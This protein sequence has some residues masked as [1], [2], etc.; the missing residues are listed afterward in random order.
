MKD[1]IYIFT[2]TCFLSTV[3]LKAT[4][5]MVASPGNNQDIQPNLQAASINASAGDILMLPAGQFVVNKCV[6]FTKALTV[7][8]MGIGQTV[9]YRSQTASDSLLTNSSQW[10]GIFKFK[11]YTNAPCGMV[12]TG[13]TFKSK[14]PSLV[15]GDGLSLAADFGII[16]DHCYNF[17]V[18]AC[19]FEN[20]GYAAVEV[21]HDDSIV[22]GLINKNEFLHNA[23]GAD[24]LGLGYG[25][26]VFGSNNKWIVNPRLGTSN[27]IFVEDNTFDFQRHA[28]AAGGCGL[29]VFRYNHVFNNIAGGGDHA[30][31]AHAARFSSG[32]NYFGTRAVEVYN[33]SLIN[34]T[35]VNGQLIVPGQSASL[36]SNN[37]ILVKAGDALIHD[38]YISGYRFGI[39][40]IDDNLTGTHPYPVLS[41]TGYL[42]GLKY[43]PNHTGWA[44]DYGDGDLYYWNTSFVPY[45][46]HD[47]SSEFYN[48]QPQYFEIYRD[49]HIV[50]KPNISNFQ[51][52][53]PLSISSAS[54]LGTGDSPSAPAFQ[55]RYL[56][57]PNPATDR[58]RLTSALELHVNID[59]QIIQSN[60]KLIHSYSLS[61]QTS[62]LDISMLPSGIYFIQIRDQEGAEI[63]KIL[64]A[65]KN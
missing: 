10:Q 19:H 15:V 38:N 45:P 12:V 43:G 58:I 35:F 50:P 28:I 9:L 55:N 11:M 21:F 48:Y 60:G 22:G 47:S 8:G 52:P 5:I 42:S 54:P 46:G 41:Q 37:G 20:F 13:I 17:V 2:L 7:K 14:K 25:V 65:R 26:A 30:V 6:L 29:Y 61:G 51:Y 18:T 24:A 33:D 27:F 44:G 49:Y 40:M 31:D 34:K 53:H 62:D 36:L 1:L 4:I 63:H 56:V 23:K 64:I 16:M 39:G 3:T 59:V 57:F 32:L